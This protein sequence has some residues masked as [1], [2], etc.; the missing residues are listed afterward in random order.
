MPINKEKSAID[1]YLTYFNGI[2]SIILD[3]KFEDKEQSIQFK[4]E[5]YVL[6]T[7]RSYDWSFAEDDTTYL[8]HDIHP[9]PAKFPPQLPAK[10][11]KMLSSIGENIWDPFGGS[12]TTALE[13]LLNDRSCVSTD[14]NPIGSIIGKAKTTALCSR[15]EKDLNKFIFRLEY[16]AENTNCLGEY[17]EKNKIKLEK[18]IPDIPNIEKWFAYAVICELAFIKQMLKNELQTDVARTIARASLSKIITKVSNQESETTYRA[19]PKEMSVGETITVFLNDLKLNYSK[20]KT[21]STIIGYRSC[22][23][24][25]ANVMESTVGE[26]KPIKK[27]AIDLVVTSPPYPNAFDYH[28]Y[29]RFRIF[30]LDGDPREMGRIEIGSHLKYQRC[31]NS[32]EQFELEMKPVLENCYSSLKAGRYAVFILGNAV[33]DG[34]EY[35]TAER[36]GELAKGLGFKKLGIIDRPLPGNKRTVKSWA[37]RATTEQILILRKPLGTFEVSLIPVQYKLYPYEKEISNLERLALSGHNSDKFTVKGDLNINNLKKLTFYNSFKCNETCFETWQS[38]LEHGKEGTISARKDPKYLTHGIHPYKG[39]FYPQLVRPLLNILGIIKGGTVFDPFCGSGTVALESILNGYNAYGCDI[40]PIA[41]EIATAKN[42][43]FSVTPYEFEKHVSIFRQ[44]LMEYCVKDY[45]DQF[46]GN[47]IDEIRSWF[48]ESV[49]NKM[50]FILS[51]IDRVPD[52]KIRCFLKVI[53]S[54]IIREISQQDPGD[55]RIRRRKEPIEDAQVIEMYI[56][57]LDIQFQNIMA[58]YKIS[59][60]APN[61]IGRANIWRG[62]STAL[63]SVQTVLP[64]EGVDIVITS[65][66]YATALPYIDTNRLNMLVLGGINASMRV[67]IEAEMTGTREIKKSTR[68]YYE[69]KIEEQEF[70]SIQSQSAKNIISKIHEQNRDANVGFRRRNMAALIYMYFRDMSDVL[71]TLD[72]VVK[73]GGYICIVIGDTK[74][75]TGTEEVVIRT[76]EVLRETGRYLGWSLIRDIPISVTVEQYVHM[77][78]SI[79]ENNI[80]VF[81]KTN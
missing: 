22:E 40:N 17:I 20:V 46:A 72:N 5:T 3:K 39:K 11:I 35:K 25:T 36:I 78:N 49:I 29:H 34:I 61:T 37:R 8:S 47:A 57:N 79:T 81:Q 44:E 62:N 28:L 33:F 18:E 77:K 12:G 32:F 69:K 41:V 19:V 31:N 56:Q 70:E 38:I 24:I 55:L 68:L 4:D 71:N 6:E 10:I 16:Y 58:F 67:P 13:A 73:T 27:E 26:D 53:L 30:W 52:E 63:N 64:D 1:K 7:L 43:I 54:S 14:I 9:Y 45:S 75:T 66:P 48:P 80:L 51:K 42:T 65:P 21:L 23:F 76:T 15:D 60:N 2:N 50:G 59:N 74:T